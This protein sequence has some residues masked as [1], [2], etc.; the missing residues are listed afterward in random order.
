[1]KT[2]KL[3]AIVLNN[4]KGIKHISI[5]DIGNELEICG[6]NA[7]GKTTVMDGFLWL[8][9]GKDSSGRTDFNIKTLDPSGEPIHNLDHEVRAILSINGEK[10]TLR[11]VYK[12]KWTKPR[13]Q[14]DLVFS[15]HETSY[16]FNEV[17]LAQKDYNAKIEQ[18]CQEKI[19]KLL[20]S[21]L[22]FPGI[23]WTEQRQ[24][25][26]QIAGEVSDGEIAET[27]PAFQELLQR[28]SNKSLEEFKREI[29]MKKKRIKDDLEV[30]P[31]RIDEVQRSMPEA[32][33]WTGIESDILMTRE[34]ISN[35]E[36][37]ISNALKGIEG[38]N[39][40]RNELQRKIL[41][42]KSEQERIE[43]EVTNQIDT[44]KFEND[45]KTRLH[46][47]SIRDL[48]DTLSQ[49]HIRMN[50]LE[51]SLQS[52]RGQR[53]SKLKQWYEINNET[54]NFNQDPIC[55]TCGQ[56]LPEEFIQS[57][58]KEAESRFNDNKAQRL[59]ANS[60]EGKVISANIQEAEKK[61]EVIKKNI[62][63]TEAK[64]QELKSQPMS[65][66]DYTAQRTV[67]LEASRYNSLQ[68][69]IS[70]L[71]NQLS[72]IGP[73]STID[74]SEL[75]NKKKALIDSL[76]TLKKEFAKKDRITAG[77]NRKTELLSDQQNLSQQL[78]DLERI[79]YTIAGFNK[80]KIEAVESRINNM[81]RIVRFRMFNQQ[82]NGGLSETCECTVDGVPYSDLNSA[83]KI[84][85]GLDI[86]STLAEKY[87][88]YAPIFI[89]NRETIN[90]LLPVKSQIINLRVSKDKELVFN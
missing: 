19:F 42:L 5:E 70:S 28:L 60:R 13:G 71:E 90:N 65:V 66:P 23:N 69:E 39:S 27:D 20:T 14:K 80:A 50:S 63:E 77:E 29:A 10:L 79:E 7:T 81:F 16:Y 56:E 61:I 22:Y 4:F 78:A 54:L 25:L 34:N 75:Q 40:K 44:L 88:I 3:Q 51:T 24:I 76:D 43:R 12:E 1:M 32:L 49:N 57:K 59:A 6:D 86:L 31:A 67:F 47:N 33:D 82:I 83:M 62:T 30:I 38:E 52:F 48:E 72:D 21:P 9:F 18:I 68:N 35:I 26:T 74:I 2:I 45:R 85:A 36:L 64:I 73:E 41:Q 87:G 55:P 17:P 84:N 46:H 58:M 15:G 89:D 11:K 8:L 53:E 37:K